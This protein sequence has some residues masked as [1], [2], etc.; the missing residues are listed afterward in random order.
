MKS[1]HRSILFLLFC[2]S[3]LLI[4]ALL[5]FYAQGYRYHFAKQRIELTGQITIET[6]PKGARVLLDG[7]APLSLQQKIT[8]Q[9]EVHTPVRLQNILSGQYTVTIEKE[10][11][12][13]L[14]KRV[15]VTPGRSFLITGVQLVKKGT[16][17]RLSAVKNIKDIAVIANG[18]IMYWTSGEVFQ[19]DRRTEKNRPLFKSHQPIE[20]VHP[21]PNGRRHLVKTSKDWWMIDEKAKARQV[22]T[23]ES[24]DDITWGEDDSTLFARSDAVVYRLNS[25]GQRVVKMKQ[26]TKELFFGSSLWA[27]SSIKS[28]R[29]VSL[30]PLSGKKIKEIKLPSSAKRII[31][32]DRQRL[33]LELV[34]E[35]VLLLNTE[36]GQSAL[37]EGSTT[38]SWLGRSTL[39]GWSDFELSLYHLN[40]E[41]AERELITREGREIKQVLALPNH[42]WLAVLSKDGSLKLYER[43]SRTSPRNAF[44][45]VQDGITVSSVAV[46]GKELL[47]SNESGLFTLKIVD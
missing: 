40:N 26:E 45:L 9:S 17:I 42:D 47:I 18:V 41:Q 16:P 22:F 20:R 21:S 35:N 15:T 24:Y 39:L 23:T 6:M 14:E 8:N 2:A 33:L 25:D 34:G 28:D 46:L 11:Y 31:G 27:L 36:N 44:N 37:V 7:K 4:G 38:A 13:A 1:Y 30:N 5:L 19:F 43:S 29:L 10:G 32:E 12:H 3:F